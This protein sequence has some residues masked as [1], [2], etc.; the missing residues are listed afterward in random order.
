[1]KT[2]KLDSLV[3]QF[4]AMDRKLQTDVLTRMV[5]QI[6]FAVQFYAAAAGIP[7]LEAHINVAEQSE[8]KHRE[9]KRQRR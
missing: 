1:M 3:E 5:L 8:D 6:E 9:M 4:F 2:H 7:L